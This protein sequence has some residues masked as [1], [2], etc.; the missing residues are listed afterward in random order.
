[1]KVLQFL[2]GMEMTEKGRGLLRLPVINRTDPGVPQSLTDLWRTVDEGRNPVL[3]CNS[4]PSLC[5]QVK[6]KWRHYGV[7]IWGVPLKLR[8]YFNTV[9]KVSEAFL[10]ASKHKGLFGI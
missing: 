2:K 8:E 6:L 5:Q 7:C 3:R 10:I 1:V 9:V 4:L